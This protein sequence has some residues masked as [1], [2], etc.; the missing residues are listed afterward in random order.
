MSFSYLGVINEDKKKL[1]NDF[2]LKMIMYLYFFTYKTSSNITLETR[3][4]NN[5]YKDE[6]KK[7]R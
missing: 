5:K 2:L 3:I 1:S 4:N 7:K 6:N